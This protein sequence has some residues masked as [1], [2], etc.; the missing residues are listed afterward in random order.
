[1][2][3]G[4]VHSSRGTDSRPGKEHHDNIYH[5]IRISPDR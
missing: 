1:M 4:K 3:A 5:L 2:L